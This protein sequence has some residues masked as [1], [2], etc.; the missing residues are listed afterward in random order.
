MKK[1]F[2]CILFALF[3]LFTAASQGFCASHPVKTIAVITDTGHRNGTTYLICGAASDIIAS[4]IINRLNQTGR[5]KAPLLG[6]NMSKITQK[7]LPLY[8][9]TFFQEYKY[10]YNVD[11]VNLKRVT[12]NMN[13]DYI[14][15]VTSGLDV[16][17]QFLK[18]NW[19]SKWGISSSEPIRPTYKLTTLVTLIDAK[20]YSVVWQ[21]IFARD[22]KS[23][24][25][26]LGIV[27]FSPSYS[28]L[29]KIKKY[30]QTMSEY[31][32]N[33]VDKEVN[34]WLVPP[35]GPKAVQ[36]KSKFINEGTK[37]YYPAVNAEVVKGNL[38]D[39]SDDTKL[40][41]EKYRKEFEAK[42]K[43]FEENSRQKKQLKE[44]QKQIKQTPNQVENSGL[45]QIYS[46]EQYTQKGESDG[47]TMPA[48]LNVKKQ[49]KVKQP[50]QKERLFDSIRNNI[51][52]VSNTLPPPR[53][54]KGYVVIPSSD[55]K[56]Q[57]P[58][59]QEDEVQSKQIDE[60][61]T[62]PAVDV[63]RT[64]VDETKKTV[65][66]SNKVNKSKDVDETDLLEDKT[67]PYYDWNIK[68]V[69][70]KKIGEKKQRKDTIKL[71]KKFRRNAERMNNSVMKAESE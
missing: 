51:E 40:R 12:K 30:S 54:D 56:M 1:F 14:M 9:V 10:N 11:F 42:K 34:P 18:E 65:P 43:Q 3:A 59:A 2:I 39:F 49:N 5:I 21:D 27:Q 61:K 32:V 52:D 16:Q 17:S 55:Y 26:D 69:D 23:E 50:K 53:E 48:V 29:E 24:N 35:E 38:E 60:V 58:Y 41:V 68:N 44:Q 15:M 62:I 66:A 19:W 63:K 47:F 31:V 8:H 28:Q 45:H 33:I 4:D 25:L 46:P 71:D 13:T 6:D 67:L 37:I 64:G 57:T 22:I 7:T 20:T 36:M 70:L